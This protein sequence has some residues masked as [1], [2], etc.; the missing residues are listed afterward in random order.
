[1]NALTFEI[2]KHIFENLGV[3]N[4]KLNLDSFKSLK[5][6]EFLLNK[7]LT[8][9]NDQEEV[10]NKVWGCQQSFGSQLMTM[11][12]AD[13]SIDNDCAYGLIVQLKDSP[14]YGL[15]FNLDDKVFDE[16][17][18]SC[19]INNKDWIICNTHLQ[20]TFLAA[21]EQIKEVGLSWRKAEDYNEQYDLM[22]SFI[23]NYDSLFGDV[24]EGQEN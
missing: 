12:L 20:A 16:T 15:Y 5:D 22:I 21:M 4:K 13:L 2:V 14:A 23:K 6:K 9:V 7:S 8:L 17:V 19:T 11:L 18:I 24:D 10:K 3:S 1:M